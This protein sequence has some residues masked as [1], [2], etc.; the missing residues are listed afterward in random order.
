[1]K[2]FFLALFFACGLAQAQ[3]V[4]PSPVPALPP[5]A[6]G[7]DSSAA[8]NPFPTEGD[9]FDTFRDVAGELRCPTCTGL[10][11]LDSD[12][13]FSIQ[14]RDLVKEQV[15]AG[16]NKAEILNYFTERYGPWIL[17]APPAKGVNALAW[18]LPLGLLVLGPLFVWFFVWRKR[19]V[20]STMGVRSSDDIL[21]EMHDELA[22]L[23]GKMGVPT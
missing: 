22:R 1:V 6:V 14:I 15:S 19:K 11:V 9:K 12:A 13:A 16:K 4:T 20:I 23:R 17:R 2:R 21:K 5:G 3:T 8:R 10:S 18:A 7:A